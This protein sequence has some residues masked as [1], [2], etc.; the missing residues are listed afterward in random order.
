MDRG[1]KIC[2]RIK[3]HQPQNE[4]R[5]K[6]ALKTFKKFK[7]IVDCFVQENLQLFQSYRFF[8]PKTKFCLLHPT[9]PIKKGIK[10]LKQIFSSLNTTA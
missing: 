5:K 3:T 4:S 2:V 8:C 7:P 10:I 9:D 1:P 6:N